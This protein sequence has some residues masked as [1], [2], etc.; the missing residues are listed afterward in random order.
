MQEELYSAIWLWQAGI[1]I[2]NF[3]MSAMQ[4][5][6]SGLHSKAGFLDPDL[7]FLLDYR[8]LPDPVT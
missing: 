6:P 1:R 7:Y 8:G 5:M 4:I 2:S 3:V